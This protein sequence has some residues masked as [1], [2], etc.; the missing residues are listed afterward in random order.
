MTAGMSREAVA[1]AGNQTPKPCQPAWGPEPASAVPEAGLEAEVVPANPPTRRWYGYELMLTDLGS[2][3]LLGVGG[4]PA[5]V[6]VVGF[7]GTPIIVHG[8]HGNA[9]LATLSPIYR[10]ALME[11]GVNIGAR[12]ES[13]SSDTLFCGLGGALWGGFF[14]M[15]GAMALDYS[16]AWQAVAPASPPGQRGPAPL[17]P[18]KSPRV[19]LTVGGVV[20]TANGATLVLGGRF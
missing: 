1:Q 3:A 15:L 9:A 8:R 7:L 4:G 13:C 2:M 20:P 17:S 14:G 12:Y 10:V 19:S 18:H 16:L 5:V 11:I 6:G